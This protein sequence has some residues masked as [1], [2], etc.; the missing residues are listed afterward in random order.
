MEWLT[1]FDLKKYRVVSMHIGP[2]KAPLYGVAKRRVVVYLLHSLN[3]FPPMEMTF[4]FEKKSGRTVV[5]SIRNNLTDSKTGVHMPVS[6]AKDFD[7]T[8]LRVIGE[9]MATLERGE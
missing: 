2:K 9:V 8:T 6:A 3:D 5:S 7:N 4:E 1:W